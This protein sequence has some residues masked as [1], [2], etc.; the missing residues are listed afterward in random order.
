MRRTVRQSAKSI[1]TGR[2]TYIGE[3]R[4]RSWRGRLESVRV[5]LLLFVAINGASEFVG[6][7]SGK[8][9]STMSYMRGVLHLR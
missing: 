5:L 7:K 4:R 9:T 6:L 2:G 1:S 3:E 8:V